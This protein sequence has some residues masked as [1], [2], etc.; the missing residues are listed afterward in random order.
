MPRGWHI[1]RWHFV[2]SK[3]PFENTGVYIRFGWGITMN[4]P[5]FYRDGEFYSVY[6]GKRLSVTAWRYAV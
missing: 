3:K 2:N 1:S 4:I 6:D 5:A